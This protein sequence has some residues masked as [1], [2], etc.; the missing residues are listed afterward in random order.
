MAGKNN[1]QSCSLNSYYLRT[2]PIRNDNEESSSCVSIFVLSTDIR[3]SLG[4]V[5][6]VIHIYMRACSLFSE[7][8]QL[9]AV[10]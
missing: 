6:E 9:L 7:T 2:S 8:L 1:L 3:E 4:F 10:L 5:S